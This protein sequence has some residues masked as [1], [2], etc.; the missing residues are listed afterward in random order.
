MTINAD[1]LISGHNDAALTVGEGAHLSVHGG[2]GADSDR[3]AGST[4]AKTAG[5]GGNAIS[6]TNNTKVLE[7]AML[8]V[9]GAAGSKGAPGEAGQCGRGLSGNAD[10][11]Y[12]ESLVYLYKVDGSLFDYSLLPIA[13]TGKL[14]ITA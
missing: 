12:C 2:R 14:I 5:N 1:S 6:V 13:L 7:S 4:E 8:L 9:Y 11:L 10:V 3:V